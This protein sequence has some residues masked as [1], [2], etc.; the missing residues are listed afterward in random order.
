MEPLFS[1]TGIV[2]G[3][4]S[5]RPVF[6]G[7]DLTLNPND[8][9]ALTGS[10]GSGKTT[11]LYLMVGLVRP[12]SGAL[13][14]FGRHRRKEA[15]FHEVRLRAGLLFD[16]SDTQLFCATVED[17]VA[18]GP[19]NLGWPRERVEAAVHDTLERLDVATCRDRSPAEL[20]HG[21][22]RLVALATIL[23][24]EPDVM[25]LDEPTNGLDESHVDTM[26]RALQTT[27]CALLIASH[28]R[29]F[30]KRVTPQCLRLD[31]GR[32]VSGSL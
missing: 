16:N 23:A 25:L 10:N 1:L 22:K 20:S 14:A 8:R 19:F 3:Y 26:V 21:E 5:E 18:F 17:D 6:N 9:V 11:L 32:I 31:Q 12:Q 24:M 28:D 4:T 2:F 15:D 27:N 30:L 13:V 29:N 7:V